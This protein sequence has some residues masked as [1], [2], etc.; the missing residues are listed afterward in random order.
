MCPIEWD[1][2][3][4]QL[5]PIIDLNLGNGSK[6]IPS[7]INIYKDE[8]GKEKAYIGVAAFS[9]L[10][11][12]R[13]NLHV[14]F[15]KKPE[16]IDGEQERLMIRFM[17]EVYILIC[18]YNSALHGKDNHIVFIATPSG[19][20]ENAKDLYGRM[21]ARAGLPVA[22]V[23]SESRAAFIKAQR[24]VISGLPQYSGKGAVV[25]DMGSST[26]DFTYLGEGMRKPIDFGYDCGASEV[27]CIM[28]KD[29]KGE[30]NDIKNFER[31]Y[32]NLIPRLLFETRR[33]KEEYYKNPYYAQSGSN[34]IMTI[35]ID[36][37]VYQDEQFEN[38]KMKFDY[39]SEKLNVK[40][41][42]YMDKIAEA[43]DDFKEK[44]ITD[45]PIYAVFLTGGASQMD[46]IKTL[47]KD[48]WD[49]RDEMI[50]RDNDPSL[51]ISHGVA[52]VGRA[53]V[54]FGEVDFDQIL[55]DAEACDLYTAFKD[56]LT[57]KITDKVT[58][59]IFSCVK[60]FRDKDEDC[61][62]A[63]LEGFIAQS[64]E[65]DIKNISEWAKECYTNVLAIKT[66][67]LQ[68]KLNSI[69]SD[70]T[71]ETMP[72][73]EPTISVAFLTFDTD[74]IKEQ[75]STICNELASSTADT[76]LAFL[77]ISA[78]GVIATLVPGGWII[79]LIGLVITSIFGKTEE[80]KKEAAMSMNLNKR[81]R[82]KVFNKFSEQW[83]DICEKVRC[84][85]ETVI[86]ENQNLK[87]SIEDCKKQ[88]VK[89]AID[90]IDSTRLMIEN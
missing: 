52:E 34:S 33:I 79:A 37:F 46:F 76:I 2:P 25:A 31:K 67:E 3:A 29:V 23:T 71:K 12:T 43:L 14:C 66:K 6:T 4:R 73:G 65:K 45:K 57:R 16:N 49:L 5:T 53:D 28:Y 42:D 64:I 89:Y 68:D 50:Y 48:K 56:S 75:M 78:G 54:R 86:A 11:P 21:A 15:K 13:A 8:N 19:W 51:T 24:D 55:R 70:Y 36:N 30:R 77:G 26:F 18:E 10:T 22:G 88:F 84:S 83:K 63:V 44:H 7:A 60:N 62:L 85:I 47:V 74:I 9:A 80:E 38:T 58:S 82:K 32:P 81:K 59:T 40:L 41:K 27:E 20:D 17:R 61:S 35:N 39:D 72:L 87:T 1:K 90:W 69:A